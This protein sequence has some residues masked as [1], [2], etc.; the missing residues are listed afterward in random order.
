MPE[1]KDLMDRSK[2]YDSLRRHLN[3]TTQNVLGTDKVLDYACARKSPINDLAYILATAWWE[4]AQTMH[5]VEEAYWMSESWRKRNLRYY[6]WHGRGL[7]QTTWERNYRVMGQRMHELGLVKDPDIFIKDPKKLKTFK[8]ALPAMFIGMEEGLYTG[9]A[10]DDYI[11]DIDENDQ[12]DLRE[13]ANARRIVNGTDKQVTIGKLA[14]HFERALK[15]GCYDPK[16]KPQEP[17]QPEPA[18]PP[19]DIPKPDD[20]HSQPPQSGF[21]VALLQSLW[22]WF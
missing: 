4:T 16:Q 12:E 10:L 6:P 15:S 3:L 9:K 19:P 14:L 5:P 21:F 2:F 13:F 11:D 7:I 20:T 17:A 1:R 18:P 22:R 8:Y